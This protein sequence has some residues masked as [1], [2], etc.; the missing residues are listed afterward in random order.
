M[1]C[2]QVTANLDTGHVF[3]PDIIR[4]D[5][6]PAAHVQWSIPMSRNFNEFRNGWGEKEHHLAVK[7]RRHHVAVYTLI[8]PGRVLWSL[9]G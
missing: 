2:V 6:L 1:S 3:G 9:T 4:T 5:K 8:G 7:N